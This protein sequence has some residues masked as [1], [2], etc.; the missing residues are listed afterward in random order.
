M[1]LRRE[2]VRNT[3]LQEFKKGICKKHN[4]AGIRKVITSK[5]WARKKDGLQGW[6]YSKTVKWYCTH[7]VEVTPAAPEN[8][9]NQIVE[10]YTPSQAASGGEING[11]PDYTLK[12]S[13]MSES[14]EQGLDKT[15]FE[16]D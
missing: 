2:S 7:D 4:I 9:S 5:K 14:S 6:S 16:T 10:S 12:R 15:V 3:T 8:S 13:D 1:N 11:L